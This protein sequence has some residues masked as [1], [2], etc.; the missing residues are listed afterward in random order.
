MN[1]ALFGERLLAFNLLPSLTLHPSRYAAFGAPSRPVP[2]ACAAAWHR[3]W[4]AAILRRLNLR[5]RPVADADRPELPLA[6]LSPDR[7]ARVARHLGAVCC[8][9]RLRR[10]IA[11]SEVRVL[12]V[13]VGGDVL[14]FARQAETGGWSRPADLDDGLTTGWA[15]RLDQIG[16]AALRHIFH[17]A[18]PEL[19]LRAELRLADEPA[20]NVP[21]AGQIP[22]DLALDI[23]ERIEPTWHSSFHA[24]R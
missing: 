23:L 5:D 13:A 8:A 3:H 22:L 7:L 20:V 18:G 2:A 6:L 19:G 16:C 21:D 4:S 11:G 14:A 9:P 12:A 15:D 10:V 24:T 17:A 1:A